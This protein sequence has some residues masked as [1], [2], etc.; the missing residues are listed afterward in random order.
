[1]K[2]DLH[3]HSLLSAKNG[4]SI[5]WISDF[6]SMKRLKNNNIEICAFTDHNDFSSSAYKSLRDLAKTG[7]ITL[8]PGI[9]VDVKRLNDTIGHLLVI[10]SNELDDSQ[11]KEIESIARK[12]L[13]KT[14]GISLQS[15][16]EIFSS[17]ETIKI[18]HVGKSDYFTNE[19][20]AILEHDAIEI[21]NYNHPNFNKWKRNGIPKSIVSFS[22]THIWK[23][24]PQQSFLITELDLK[25]KTFLDLKA[26]LQ[27][28]LDF[29]KERI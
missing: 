16:N 8:L 18:P 27:K 1:M 22:D 20:L 10:F 6:D 12:D 25:E 23:D 9:E 7:G 19:D 28:N 2:I 5:H 11:L 17:F 29:T 13:K 14:R 4:D 21:S 24:Y 26:C 3:L 15:A